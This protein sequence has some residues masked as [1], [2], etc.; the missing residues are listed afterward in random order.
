MKKTSIVKEN[1]KYNLGYLV[2]E[3]NF[4]LIINEKENI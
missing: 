4:Y 2:Y 1:T 3:R